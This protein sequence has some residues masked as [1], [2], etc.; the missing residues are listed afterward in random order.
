ML[1]L[2]GFGVDRGQSSVAKSIQVRASC[3]YLGGVAGSHRHYWSLGRAVVA[4]RPSC[5]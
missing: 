5:P 1:K 4:C 3:I 2:A